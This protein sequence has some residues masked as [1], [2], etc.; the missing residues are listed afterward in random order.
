LTYSEVTATHEAAHAVTA[1]VLGYGVGIVQICEC[2]RG[3]CQH[4]KA[5]DPDNIVI[6]LAG[7]TAVIKKF[8]ES[9]ATLSNSDVAPFTEAPESERK[10]AITRA[11][12]IVFEPEYWDLIERIARVLV[13]A[14]TFDAKSLPPVKPRITFRSFSS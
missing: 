3:Y 6:G 12:E 11:A 4:D 13:T 2:G 8:G 7:A 5:S 9:R 14:G 10:Q 1:L